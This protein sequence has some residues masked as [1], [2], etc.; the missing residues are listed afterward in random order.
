MYLRM[1]RRWALVGGLLNGALALAE[2]TRGPK[3]EKR[4]Q[5]YEAVEIL[6]AG[7]EKDRAQRFDEAEQKP[8][9]HAAHQRA[10]SADDDDLES[11]ESG[12][13]TVLGVDEEV[14]GQERAGGGCERHAHSEGQH[15][16]PQDVH[17]GRLYSH[18]V[19]RGAA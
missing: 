17:A 15:V 14:R 19:L 3:C 10:Q 13:R 6:V 1:G 2:K 7:G 12:D 5:E 4:E 16:Q 8:A 18:A 11:L 9:H